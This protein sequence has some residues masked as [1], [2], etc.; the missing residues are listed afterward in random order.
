M[1]YATYFSHI[2]LHLI[3]EVACFTPSTSSVTKPHLYETASILF[4]PESIRRSSVR[5]V[6]RRGSS[7]DSRK[8]RP[9][10]SLLRAF[11]LL[12]LPS[13]TPSLLRELHPR[14]THSLPPN[15]KFQVTGTSTSSKISSADK[16]AQ[17]LLS[18]HP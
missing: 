6:R 17:S 8:S 9:L 1:K 14:A 13:P 16:R 12:G 10:H 18:H 5:N 2:K 3:L 15:L 7:L 4:F 11:F